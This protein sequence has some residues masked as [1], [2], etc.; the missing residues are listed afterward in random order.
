MY[1]THRGRCCSHLRWPCCVSRG[2]FSFSPHPLSL[3]NRCREQGVT[4]HHSSRAVFAHHVFCRVRM[5]D[6]H[7]FVGKRTQPWGKRTVT[8]HHAT[9]KSITSEILFIPVTPCSA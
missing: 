8:P 5:Y 6:K 1:A 3:Y 9:R 2:P 7:S 4:Q